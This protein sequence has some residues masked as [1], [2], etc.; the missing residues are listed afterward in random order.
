[1]AGVKE[2][3]FAGQDLYNLL[4][5]YTDG[6]CPLNGEVRELLVHPNVQR[7]IAIKVRS[8]EWASSEPLFLQYDGKRIASWSKGQKAEQT[9]QQLNETPAR[10]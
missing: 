4:V 10:Q 6:I 9:W 8:A 7:K 2:Y 3:E 5:H 1:M